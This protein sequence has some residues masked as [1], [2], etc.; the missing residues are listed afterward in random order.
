MSKRIKRVDEDKTAKSVW[1]LFRNDRKKIVG[2]KEGEQER[3]W[4]PRDGHCTHGGRCER[5]CWSMLE[6]CCELQAQPSRR[7]RKFLE[8]AAPQ[9]MSWLKLSQ[10]RAKHRLTG[11]FARFEKDNLVYQMLVCRH[12]AWWRQ[13]QRVRG[14]TKFGGAHQNGSTCGAGRRPT[15]CL[16]RAHGQWAGTR[17]HRTNAS[18]KL[19][20]EHFSLRVADFVC[21]SRVEVMVPQRQRSI[22]VLHRDSSA[23]FMMCGR[24]GP[25]FCCPAK[26]ISCDPETEDLISTSERER[27]GER[28]DCDT[29]NLK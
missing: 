5:N 19:E 17:W 1:D 2:V 22:S 27:E 14:K 18:G 12:L 3:C 25:L 16:E 23:S 24:G 8:K 29:L 15:S 11:H 13:E 7:L 26:H 10:P 6:L 20:K 21:G 9:G 4:T 28:Y